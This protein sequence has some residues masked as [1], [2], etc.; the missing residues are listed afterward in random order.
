MNVVYSFS[1][2]TNF[3]FQNQ[4]KIYF[5]IFVIHLNDTTL[6]TLLVQILV[7]KIVLLSKLGCFSFSFYLWAKYELIG[8]DFSAQTVI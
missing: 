1:C 3:L 2:K 8:T 6:K 7:T 5:Q 4:A